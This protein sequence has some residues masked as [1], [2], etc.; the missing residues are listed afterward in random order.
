MKYPRSI[1]DLGSSAKKGSLAEAI[2]RSSRSNEDTRLLWK[3]ARMAMKDAQRMRRLAETQIRELSGREEFRQR[4]RDSML[5][6]IVQTVIESTA[7]T[8]GLIQLCDSASLRLTAQ[9]CEGFPVILLEEIFA[10][11]ALSPIVLLDRQRLIVEDVT[12]HPL[13]QGHPCLEILL[14][15]G[16]RAFQSTPLCELRGTVVGVFST[17]YAIPGS[18]S[19]RD[20]KVV[21]YFA[22][23][24][25]NLIEWR[26]GRLPRIPLPSAFK[27]ADDD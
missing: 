16:V 18:P 20:L 23:W 24:A 3:Q 5:S 27:I 2:E 9:A 1:M 7:A 21:D 25:A 26:D 22:P 6:R 19:L 12:N 4:Y 11:A 15:A 8:I 17:C 14:D 10:V 13:F